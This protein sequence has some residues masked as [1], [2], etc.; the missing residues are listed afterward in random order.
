VIST[1][2]NNNLK[3]KLDPA[4]FTSYFEQGYF[5]DENTPFENVIALP[6]NSHVNINNRININSIDDTYETAFTWSVSE[7][8]IDQIN[9][10]FTDA[11]KSVGD[12]N[13][14]IRSGLTGGKD[15]RLILLALLENNFN[16]KSH[17]TGFPDPPDVT[18]AQESAEILEVP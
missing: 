11:F 8:L 9:K 3:P 16:V 13:S 18:V 5:A 7:S 14:L 15:S 12:K 4:N 2:S 10:D 1:L 17:T 6:E